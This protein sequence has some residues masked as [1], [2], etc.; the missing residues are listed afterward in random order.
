MASL[1]RNLIDANGRKLWRLAVRKAPLHS[2]TNAPIDSVPAGAKDARDFAPIH[3]PGP[4]SKEPLIGRRHLL[5]ATGPCKLL[6][7]YAAVFA[8]DAP[9]GIQKENLQSENGH[10]LKTP[11]LA[12]VVD[13]ARLATSPTKGLLFL[14]ATTGT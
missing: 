4:R 9:D 1:V 13:C 10:E 14:R 2:V 8:I 11:L 6:G 3:S 5:L 7:L 12:C